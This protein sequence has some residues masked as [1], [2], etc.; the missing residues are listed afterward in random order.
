MIENITPR[1]WYV[2]KIYSILLSANESTGYSRVENTE[3]GSGRV[4]VY[5][6]LFDYRLMKRL[7]GRNDKAQVI[8]ESLM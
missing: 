1:C 5:K 8:I 6:L 2:L 7:F 3:D 4:S